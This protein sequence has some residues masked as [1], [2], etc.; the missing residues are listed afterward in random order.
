M[1]TR[2]EQCDGVLVS[3]YVYVMEADLGKRVT[4]Y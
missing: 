4:V 3:I 1:W 2:E